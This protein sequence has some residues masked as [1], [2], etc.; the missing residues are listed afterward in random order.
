MKTR[1]SMAT[2]I[3]CCLVVFLI[4]WAVPKFLMKENT[5]KEETV[6]SNNC[7]NIMYQ[8]RIKKYDLVEPLVLSDVYNESSSLSSLRAKVNEYVSQLI[9]NKDA[10]DISV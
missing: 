6:I 1:V 5:V 3:I 8:T 4:S 7:D 2:L 10:D 9:S